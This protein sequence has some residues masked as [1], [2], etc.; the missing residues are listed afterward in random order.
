M[1]ASYPCDKIPKISNSK[2]GVFAVVLEVFFHHYLSLW[3]LELW[4]GRESKPEA[5]WRRVAH[6][7]IVREV[8]EWE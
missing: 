6:S 4:A 1:L 2:E 7:V 8:K 5:T 3:H